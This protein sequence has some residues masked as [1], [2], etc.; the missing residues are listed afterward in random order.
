MDPFAYL[1]AYLEH[2]YLSTHPDLTPAARDLVHEQ[3]LQHPQTY[4]NSPHAQALLSYANAHRDL[5]RGLARIEEAP[6]EEFERQ[7]NKLFDAA[8]IEMA[9]IAQSDRLCVDAHL[10][11]IMLADVPL[12]ACLMDLIGLEGRVRSHLTQSNRYFDADAP[13]K[14]PHFWEPDPTDARS[15]AERTACDPAV[16]GW[17]H[18]VEALAQLSLASSRYRAAAAYARLIMRAQGYPNYAVGTLM[19]ALARLEDED[20]FFRVAD[21]ADETLSVEDS[22]WYLLARTILLYKLGRERNA[23]RALK[24][25]SRR[26]DGGAFFLLNP[27]YLT[28]YLPV[29]PPVDAVWKLTHQAVWEADGIIADTPDFSPWAASVE[30]IEDDAERFA[31]RHGF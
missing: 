29:R 22:P 5:Q 31:A 17:L 20:A 21:T 28:P 10:L 30:G 9:K 27:V 2:D 11:A 23:R 1:A 12:D 26:C 16:I 7:R 25:F 19:L 24:D 18:T 8:R 15:D 6:D 4:A 14:A 13:E 3:I